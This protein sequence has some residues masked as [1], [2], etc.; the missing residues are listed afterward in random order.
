[1]LA[2]FVDHEPVFNKAQTTQQT[3]LIT[4]LFGTQIDKS[5]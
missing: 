4:K 2:I 3:Q 5:N 1:M